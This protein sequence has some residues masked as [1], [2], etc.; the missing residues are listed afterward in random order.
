MKKL[1]FVLLGGSVFLTS[2]VDNPEGKKLKQKTVYLPL[3]PW[4]VQASQLILL[5]AALPG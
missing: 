5:P 3:N 4:P 1:L 2:C